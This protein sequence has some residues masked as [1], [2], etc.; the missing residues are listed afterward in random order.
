VDW[1]TGGVEILRKR[2]TCPRGMLRGG[3]DNVSARVKGHRKQTK[4]NK[5][6]NGGRR[7]EAP[8]GETEKKTSFMGGRALGDEVT[9]NSW[10]G[11]G[12]EKDSPG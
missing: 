5:R 4:G 10:V 3:G 12:Q 9:D 7:K 6:I 8:A 1:F 2:A 11:S